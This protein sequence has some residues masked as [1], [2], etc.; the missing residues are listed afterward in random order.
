MVL[1]SIIHTLLIIHTLYIIH[2]IKWTIMYYSE[3]ITK[4]VATIT[5]EVAITNFTFLKLLWKF[6]WP[7]SVIDKHCYLIDQ[8]IRILTKLW[9]C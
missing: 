2:I 3:F 8:K 1:F 7:P 9:K 6:C 4:E 5:K